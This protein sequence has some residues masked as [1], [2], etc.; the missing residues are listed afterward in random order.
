[1]QT[2]NQ[3]QIAQIL[4]EQYPTPEQRERLFNLA[5]EIKCNN[6]ELSR[7]ECLETAS[8]TI[9]NNQVEQEV[10]YTRYLCI[11]CDKGYFRFFILLNEEGQPWPDTQTVEWYPLGGFEKTHKQVWDNCQFLIDCLAD[12]KDLDREGSYTVQKARLEIEKEGV[13]WHRLI[14]ILRCAKQEGWLV[15]ELRP[16]DNI[17]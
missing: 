5:F 14:K 11:D 16:A 7:L 8:I 4:I 2:H 10:E 6:P 17:I 1:M 9:S 12:P 15:Q 3:E 13:E